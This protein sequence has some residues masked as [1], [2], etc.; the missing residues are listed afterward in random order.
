MPR[1]LPKPYPQP[2]KPPVPTP[3]PESAGR[4]PPPPPPRPRPESDYTDL[5]IKNLAENVAKTYVPYAIKNTESIDEITFDDLTNSAYIYVDNDGHP[6]KLVLTTVIHK[7][8]EW[9]D[10]SDE[11]KEQILKNHL[12]P[13]EHITISPDGVISAQIGVETVNGKTGNVVLTANDVNA[14]TKEVACT[15]QELY[16]AIEGIDIT[17]DGGVVK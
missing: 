5:K 1:E 12:T 17:I 2:E 16:D 9:D 15:K 4:F 13:G 14:Y 6:T 11:V 10:L 3:H 8:V 7:Q